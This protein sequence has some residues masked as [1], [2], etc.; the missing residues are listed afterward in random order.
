MV[1]DEASWR[2]PQWLAGGEAHEVGYVSET[3]KADKWD[4][5]NDASKETP[6]HEL[7]T[8]ERLRANGG[9]CMFQ[10]DHEYVKGDDGGL[11]DRGLADLADGTELKSLHACSSKD[12]V[13]SHMKNA[14]RK[15]DAVRVVFDN[16]RN[17]GMSDDELAECLRHAQAFKRGTVHVIDSDGI[18]TRIK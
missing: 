3:A 13:Y 6:E 1:D 16:S 5:V 10:I 11:V 9:R 17:R 8:A 15:R 12:M 2:D 14:S 7:E 4:V 18:L